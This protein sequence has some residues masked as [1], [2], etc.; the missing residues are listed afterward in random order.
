VAGIG[1]ERGLQRRGNAIAAA[2]N[3]DAGYLCTSLPVNGTSGV[4]YSGTIGD[5]GRRA[6]SDWE[7]A[8]RRQGSQIY[9]IDLTSPLPI[10]CYAY[11]NQFNRS[12]LR[13]PM[14]EVDSL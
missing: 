13:S 10:S 5:A 14:N 11:R 6:G 7:R 12:S 2:S 1:E 8:W 4:P 3:R 9:S